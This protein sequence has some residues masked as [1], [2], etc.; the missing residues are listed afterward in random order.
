MTPPVVETESGS[1]APA[2]GEPA[3][4]PPGPP[5]QGGMPT[6][7][8]GDLYASQGHIEQALDVYR[9]LMA[10]QPDDPEI[11]RRVEELTM[12]AHAKSEAPASSSA[13]PE[14]GAEGDDRAIREAIHKLEGW[15]AAIR[16]S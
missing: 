16:K 14:V 15:L 4:G 13:Q 2:A 6:A 9:Q 1:P 12:L 8:L 10:S 11:R 7:T 3:A 5:L